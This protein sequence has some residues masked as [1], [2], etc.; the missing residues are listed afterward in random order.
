MQHWLT[1][2]LRKL[3]D[4]S[5]VQLWH[6][7]IQA[8]L[9]TVVGLCRLGVFSPG[10]LDHVLAF[11]GQNIH[12]LAIRILLHSLCPALCGQAAQERAALGAHRG[13]RNQSGIWLHPL[14]PRYPAG[15]LHEGCG[16]Q[17]LPW[18]GEASPRLIACRV[19]T[20]HWLPRVPWASHN[21]FLFR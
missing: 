4:K 14:R 17:A 21:V 1:P 20:R 8:C 9:L 7:A 3:Y 6:D 19:A 18:M 12:S 5:P 11:A 2:S 13:S 15:C 10:A 16:W